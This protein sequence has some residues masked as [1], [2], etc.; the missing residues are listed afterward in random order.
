[1]E[2]L[3]S[4]LPGVPARGAGEEEGWEDDGVGWYVPCGVPENM[5][6]PR[7]VVTNTLI[8]ECVCVPGEAG[9]L[10]WGSHGCFMLCPASSAPPHPTS[11]FVL[12]AM[13]APQPGGGKVG[14]G[15]SPSAPCPSPWGPRQRWGGSACRGGHGGNRAQPSCQ[16]GNTVTFA[17]PTK[18]PP[19]PRSLSLMH[20]RERGPRRAPVLGCFFCKADCGK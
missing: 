12:S 2:L 20:V 5:L 11:H 1:M 14:R 9:G 4:P 13:A 17:R 6:F 16:V 8:R 3:P 10:F 18:L 7:R 19:L 15:D